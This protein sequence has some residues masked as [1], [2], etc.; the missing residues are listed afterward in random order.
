MDELKHVAGD[1]DLQE[2]ETW[3]HTILSTIKDT[4]TTGSVTITFSAEKG[5]IRYASFTFHKRGKDGDE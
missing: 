2:W 1:A 3:T 5:T 4:L